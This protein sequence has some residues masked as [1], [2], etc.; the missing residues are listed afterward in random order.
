MFQECRFILTSGY[1]C[2]SPALRGQEFCY[3][4]TAARRYAS[5]RT[6]SADP[7]QFPSI[8]R[9]RSSDRA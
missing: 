9:C 1:K 2:K 8:E 7:L 5:I 3:F 4:H 6:S